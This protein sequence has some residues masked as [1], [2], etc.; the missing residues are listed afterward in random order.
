MQW[1]K[2]SQLLK[3]ALPKITIKRREKKMILN[4]ANGISILVL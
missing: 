1:E 3:A 4:Y 2:R